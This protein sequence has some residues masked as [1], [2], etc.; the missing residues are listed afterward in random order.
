MESLNYIKE[1]MD[2][3]CH[4]LSSIDTEDEAE[5]ICRSNAVRNRVAKLFNAMRDANPELLQYNYATSL[6]KEAVDRII[7]RIAQNASRHYSA[8]ILPINYVAVDY[9]NGDV[10]V[11]PTFIKWQ[12]EGNRRQNFVISYNEEL[13]LNAKRQL[14]VLLQNMLLCFPP[15]KILFNIFDQTMSG[16]AD[17]LTVGYDEAVYNGSVIMDESSARNCIKRLR[18]RMQMVMG[19]YGDVARYNE[20]HRDIHIPYEI[21]VLNDYPARYENL[22]AEL[23]PLFENGAKGGIYFIIMHNTDA[24]KLRDDA[25]DILSSDSKTQLALQTINGDRS[26]ALVNYTPIAEHTHLS[27]AYRINFNNCINEKTVRKV[28]KTDYDTLTYEEYNDAVSEISITVGQDIENNDPIT[29]KFNSGDY[30]H[31]FILGQS[32]SGKSVLLNNI[33]S[34]AIL[35]YS[36]EDLMLYLM[37]FKGVEFNRYRGVKHVKALL[38][39]N[40]DP[41]MTLEVLREL[42]EENKK[43]VKLWRDNSV[44]NIDGYNKKNPDSK[45]PQILF[46]A[47]ECQV[48]F[49]KPASNSYAMAIQR[50]ISEILNVIATQGRSQGIHMLLATQQLDETDISGQILKNLTECFLLMSAASDSNKLV[51]DSSDLTG[52][53]PTG[54]ACYYHKKELESIVQTFYAT[55]EELSTAINKARQKSSD[56]QSNGE[57]YFNGSSMY[58]LNTEDLMSA[59]EQSYGALVATVGRSIGLKQQSTAI[60]LTQDF[61]ENVIVWGANRQEQSTATAI[62]ALVSLMAYY[63]QSGIPCNFLVLDFTNNPVSQCKPLLKEL[64]KR[65]YCK[66]IQQSESGKYLKMVADDIYNDTAPNLILTILGHER[67]SDMKRNSLLVDEKK[68]EQKKN[69]ALFGI[70]MLSFE[71]LPDIGTNN[72]VEGSKVKKYQEALQ[73]ILDEGPKHNVHVLMQ[74]DK[75]G[76]IL[77][78][79]FGREAISKFKHRV[80]LKSE[81]KHLSPLRLGEDIDVQSLSDDNEHLR[82]YYYPDGEQPMLF[83]P[84]LLPD[85]QNI[86]NAVLIK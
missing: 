34:A 70:E 82:A 48:M 24:K 17:Y 32:G 80:I 73:Y 78:D 30:I 22:T 1:L 47:D 65:G 86:F 66:I 27:D 31:G 6:S 72:M 84:F 71:P 79:E 25:A 39:D 8:P 61:C 56:K 52:K 42:Q 43:R 44:N 5:Y 74:V 23:E 33:I 4:E 69:E 14:N 38:V 53:Q 63:H 3:Y 19:K 49:A 76:N 2:T 60:T 55:D 68:P 64:D 36:P 11:T 67:F 10:F 7:N 57:S 50:E 12:R 16:M 41:Q 85:M 62:N 40:S 37:D 35:K 13:R 20:T 54:Q 46:V 18:E 26:S 59:K 81:N 21:V 45:L 58:E 29:L 28:L 15:G 83:T 75:P 51:P 9:I 77:F